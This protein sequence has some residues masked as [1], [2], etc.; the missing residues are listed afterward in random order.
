MKTWQKIREHPELLPHYFIRETVVDTIRTFFKSQ[1]FHE[2]FTPILVPVPSAESNLE[3]FE[4][5]L[6]TASGTK[7]RGFLIMSPEFSIKKLLSAGIGNCF[8]I[9]R[10]FRNEEEVSFSHNPEFTMLEWYRVGANYK[11][12]MRDFENLFIEIIKNA[13]PNVDLSRWK[14]QGVAYDL[15]L[16]WPRISI[17]EAFLTY[18]GVDT[19]ILLDKDKLIQKAKV[20]GYAI[21]EK[22]TWEEVFYQLFFNEIEPKLKEGRKPIFI[23][24][25]PLAQAS[26]SRRCNDD[27]R[28]AERFE[29]FL[30]GLELGNCFSEL[31]DAKE[32]EERFRVDLTERKKLH[33]TE[34]PIDYDLIEA[35]KIGLPEVSGIAVGVD[36][37]VM[38]A[39]NVPTISD[40][41]FF[42]AKELFD[43]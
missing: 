30:A 26:L 6:R 8:E 31:T 17:K 20:K 21:L 43:L 5:Q 9:T 40:T 36:R 23:Y 16:P 27:P 32:Q 25:Y 37:L 1:G 42:P 12:V 11:D 7:R 2:V 38:L 22:T 39:S 3:V 13:Q 35:L 24:D 14:Y 33:K 10:D 19:E 28:F 15:S 29:V 4:T 41:L 18:C 34:Y